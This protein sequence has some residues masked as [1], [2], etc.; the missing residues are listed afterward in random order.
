MENCKNTGNVAEDLAADALL[1]RGFRDVV[2]LNV[3]IRQHFPFADLLAEENGI[4]YAVSVK[5]RNRIT[6]KGE[7][8]TGYKVKRSDASLA[9]DEIR[10]FRGIDCVPAFA[11][12]EF[13]GDRYSVY[14]DRLERSP[15]KNRIGMKESERA[16]YHCLVQNEFH[17]RLIRPN[18]YRIQS[19]QAMLESAIAKEI[20]DLCHAYRTMPKSDF[21]TLLAQVGPATFQLLHGVSGAVLASS[22]RK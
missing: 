13:D 2:N 21:D 5:G 1:R 22:R 17:H 11:A 10:R 9:I 8:N 12:V 15:R 16:N 18:E 6:S 7:V 3:V 14:F 19:E 4:W 20:L